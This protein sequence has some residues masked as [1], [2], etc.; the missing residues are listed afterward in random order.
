M[1]GR[2]ERWSYAAGDLGF[3]FV[4]QSTE[5]YLLFYYVRGLGLSP[6]V[7][8]AI[9]LAGAVVDWISDP[10]VGALADRLAPRVPL[11]AWVAVGGPLSVLLL[12]AAF[13]PPPVG[14]P[15]LP[16]YALAT[17]LALRFAYSLGNI[18]Y[19][20]LTARISPE[21]AD[22]LSLTGIRMQGAALGGLIAA[23]TYVLLPARQGG[24]ADFRLGALILA[25][26]AM[27]AF[28]ATC[29]GTRER[30]APPPPAM[31]STLAGTVRS[32][33]GL[34]V[35]SAALRR[36][37]ATI[38]AAGL[39]VT[40]VDK[41]LLFLFEELGAPRL[42]YYMALVPSLALLLSAPLWARLGAWIGRPRTLLAA[43]ALKLVAVLLALAIGG[44]APVALL[45]IV[46]IVAGAG[47]SVMFWSLVPA[48]VAACEREALSAGYAGRVYALSTI[49]RKLAQALAP[50]IIALT[51]LS[52][53]IG[54]LWG[55]AAAALAAFVAVWLYPPGGGSTRSP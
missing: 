27:P 23:A 20:A 54:V 6:G 8:A 5:L 31:P 32:M 50:Q 29:L 2:R 1:I 52:P 30:V 22:H 43:A 53:R 55:I 39:A 25:G 47:M 7:A 17:Y 46:S 24:G 41:S 21:P 15:L 9:F 34:L 14:R 18:P 37:L 38:L 33:G 35:R 3:N 45:I 42:G 10:L 51:L 11:R 44:V 26:L 49:A 16:V 28:L 48:A 4:W 13:T 40:V 19:A 12:T 36:L